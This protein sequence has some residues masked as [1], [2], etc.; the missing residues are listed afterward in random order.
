[1]FWTESPAHEQYLRQMFVFKSPLLL[2][3]C[4]SWRAGGD[5]AQDMLEQGE[6]D[7]ESEQVTRK[8]YQ[9]L[10][11]FVLSEIQNHWRTPRREM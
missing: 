10:L 2:E 11:V 4:L 7:G 8:Q 6:H 9:G 3:Q 1:M 5:K